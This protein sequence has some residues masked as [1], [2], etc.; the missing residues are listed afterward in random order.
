M[1]VAGLAQGAFVGLYRGSMLTLAYVGAGF[2]IWNWF[3]RPIEEGDLLERFGES[4]ERYRAN[5]K[6]WI[7][8]LSRWRPAPSSGQ[9]ER[10]HPTGSAGTTT[11]LHGHG[12][13]PGPA[14]G[15]LG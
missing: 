6:C 13:D 4:Y 9:H 2:L 5:V 15:D 10:R 12:D 14:D 1:A 11:D 3:V 8:R 7:P